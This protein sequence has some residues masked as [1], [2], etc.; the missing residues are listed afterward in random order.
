MRRADTHTA[1]LAPVCVCG[2]DVDRRLGDRLVRHTRDDGL[3]AAQADDEADLQGESFGGAGLAHGGQG[4]W[5]VLE[6]R[7]F[8]AERSG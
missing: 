8:V 1:G 4:G 7:V 6:Q 3:V 2:S 5:H